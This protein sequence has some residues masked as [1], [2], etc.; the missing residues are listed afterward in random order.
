MI[1][2]EKE[3][4]IPLDFDYESLIQIVVRYAL[5]YEACPYEAEVNV[6]LTDDPSICE[7]NREYRQMDRPTDVLSF[8]MLEYVNPG[9]FDGLEDMDEY[10]NPETGEL[11]LGDIMISLEKVKEQA[12]EYGHSQQRELGFLVAHSMLHL[13][14]YDHMEQQDRDEMERRQSEI[15]DHLGI[16]R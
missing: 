12:K 4:E 16:C 1:Y 13:F 10:F 2:I 14:G 8:P 15:L 11:V 6:V 9:N 7:I 3:T 5:D